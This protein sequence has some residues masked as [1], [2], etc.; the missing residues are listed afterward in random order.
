MHSRGVWDIYRASLYECE[1]QN[2]S[3]YH[4][5]MHECKFGIWERADRDTVRCW[6]LHFC[7]KAVSTIP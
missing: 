4:V 2:T 5:Y 7:S 1:G 6:G 3:L